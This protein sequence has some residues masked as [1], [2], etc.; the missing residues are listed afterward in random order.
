LRNTRIQGRP[1]ASEIPLRQFRIIEAVL[2]QAIPLDK[3]IISECG[4]AFFTI[5]A[6]SVPC[7]KKS[8]NDQSHQLAQAPAPHSSW[9][10]KS[11]GLRT[12]VVPPSMTYDP[13]EVRITKRAEKHPEEA[14]NNLFSRQVLPI[15]AARAARNGSS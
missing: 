14:F 4:T 3:H 5:P 13:G 11:K 15:T 9:S 10:N 1:L 8:P 6:R 7:L 2:G 12:S